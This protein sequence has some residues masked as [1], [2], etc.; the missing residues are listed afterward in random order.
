MNEASGQHVKSLGW[1]GQSALCANRQARAATSPFSDSHVTQ[2]EGAWTCRCSDYAGGEHAVAPSFNLILI[3]EA[4]K[5]VSSDAVPT[6]G[7]A[8]PLRGALRKLHTHALMASAVI[9]QSH[10]AALELIGCHAVSIIRDGQSV[11]NGLGQNEL[12]IARARVPSIR[13]QFR[14]RQLGLSGELTEF[15]NQIVLFE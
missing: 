9:A 8:R 10:P 5:A 2:D 13:N 15:A 4:Q 7:F 1:I 12:N 11:A 6:I 14:Q 3:G